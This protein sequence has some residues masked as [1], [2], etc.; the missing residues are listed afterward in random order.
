MNKEKCNGFSLVYNAN[1]LYYFLINPRFAFFLN[2]FDNIGDDALIEYKDV[3]KEE[4]VMLLNILM[5]QYSEKIIIMKEKNELIIKN[6]RKMCSS[7]IN[8]EYQS[9]EFSYKSIKKY[10]EE[11]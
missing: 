10:V 4:K 3:F 11:A 8:K 9:L 2:N 5:Y 7:D 6:I 1:A